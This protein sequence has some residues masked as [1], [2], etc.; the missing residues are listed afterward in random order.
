MKQR[1][2]VKNRK[3]NERRSPATAK[4]GRSHAWGPMNGNIMAMA[5]IVADVRINGWVTGDPELKR[6]LT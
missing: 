5:K 1:G 2:R 4:H 3:R 6:S